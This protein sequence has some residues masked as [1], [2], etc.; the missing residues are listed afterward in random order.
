M[1]IISLIL[2][3]FFVKCSKALIKILETPE[4]KRARRLAKKEAK[5]RWRRER[6]GWDKEYLGYTNED[7]PFGDHHLSESFVWKRKLERQGLSHLS[8]E[9][10]GFKLPVL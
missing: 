10:V 5:E 7:N 2:I 9:E 3:I 8:K 4:E 1:K 6:M